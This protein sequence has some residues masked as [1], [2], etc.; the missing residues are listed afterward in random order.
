MQNEKSVTS[1][2]KIDLTI[3]IMPT[4]LCFTQSFVIAGHR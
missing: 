1:D 4:T 3:A 2:I